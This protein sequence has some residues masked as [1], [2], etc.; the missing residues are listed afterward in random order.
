M[1]SGSCSA[2]MI[3]VPPCFGATELGGAPDCFELEPHAPSTTA[4]H[5]TKAPK[6][7][8]PRRSVIGGLLYRAAHSAWAAPIPGVRT[9]VLIMPGPCV[10]Y[11]C[12]L[13]RRRRPR[14]DATGV[15]VR[16]RRG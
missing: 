13:R 15:D 6:R 4:R 3:S 2:P 1:Q 10:C 7:T 11:T 14:H 12:K 8:T 9:L 5:E 16:R